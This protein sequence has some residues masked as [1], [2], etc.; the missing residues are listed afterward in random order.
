MRWERETRCLDVA[1]LESLL[2]DVGLARTRALRHR[3]RLDS[4]T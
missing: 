1:R 4:R 2:P 3:G